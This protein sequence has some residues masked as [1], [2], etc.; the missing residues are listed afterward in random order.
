MKL[1]N[2]TFIDKNEASNSVVLMGKAVQCK[3]LN[4][5]I[6]ANNIFESQVAYQGGALY[7]TQIEGSNV[8]YKIT[9]NVFKTNEAT[10]GG[11]IYIDD[12]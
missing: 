10:Q 8:T 6:F 3:C 5:Q 7:L 11:A 4:E 1:I 12:A 2:N 9:K